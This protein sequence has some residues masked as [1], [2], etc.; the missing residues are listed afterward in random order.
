MKLTIKK[1]N[2]KSIDL[3]QL[4]TKKRTKRDANECEC[5]EVC[6]CKG[7]CKCKDKCTCSYYL[8]NEVNIIE[9]IERLYN[10]AQ[11]AVSLYEDRYKPYDK[12]Y[13]KNL[14]LFLKMINKSLTN[15]NYNKALDA[16]ILKTFYGNL[17]TLSNS[18]F[19]YKRTN[20]N[21]EICK[22][23]TISQ[24][25]LGY[26]W[27]AFGQFLFLTAKIKAISTKAPQQIS[28][29]EAHKLMITLKEKLHKLQVNA[30][31]SFQVSMF[32]F[33][34]KLFYNYHIH[35][36][37]SVHNL[38][39]ISD[40]SNNL[41]RVYD[42]NNPIEPN[43]KMID[44]IEQAWKESCR[45]NG[46]KPC[47]IVAEDSNIIQ[48]KYLHISTTKDYREQDESDS[49]RVYQY[50]V[51]DRKHIF[52]SDHRLVSENDD[53]IKIRISKEHEPFEK[54]RYLEITFKD[55]FKFYKIKS[56]C[57]IDLI[58][59]GFHIGTHWIHDLIVFSR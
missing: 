22:K 53:K 54:C 23:P 49:K 26:H 42:F 57:R 4:K 19:D 15:R 7:I 47:R 39:P 36:I 40:K 41:G 1:H 50:L 59:T 31:A 38:V 58:R 17:N 12:P 8:S 56:K 3:L 13:D 33:E 5:E 11:S 51:N 46:I 20:Y 2:L 48:R 35:I 21:I 24:A 29:I 14:S 34:N 9:R 18:H 27:K 37:L 32:N 44:K 25:P 16:D 10:P 55:F 52:G 30:T 45:I 6:K 43:S 28:K